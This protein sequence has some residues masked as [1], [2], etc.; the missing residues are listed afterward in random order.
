MFNAGEVRTILGGDFDAAGFDRFD[1]ATRG[2]ARNA[3][4]AEASIGRSA[5][6]ANASMTR[7]SAAA[8]RS[9]RS[10]ARY[11]AA[12][13]LAGA[14]IAGGAAL[15]AVGVKRSLNA[16][17]DFQQTLSVF[18]A[19]AGAT[20]RQMERV[21]RTAMALG[22]DLTLPGVSAADAA[23]AMTELA[24]GGLSVADSMAAA[25][26]VLQL[27]TAAQ[28]G[29]ADA[30]TIT[31]D[32]LNAFGL[33]GN[34]A[35]DVADMLANAANKSTATMPEMAEGLK[36]VSAVAATN[37]LSISTVVTALA[38]LAN[39]GIKGSDAGTSLKTM[40]TS[41][42]APTKE[43]K[44]TLSDMGVAVFDAQGAMRPFPEIIG[45]LK[46]ATRGMSEEQRAAAFNT[47]F[48]ADAVRAANVLVGEGERKH[49]ALARGIRESGAAAKLAAA[50]T[51]G[52]NGAVG[53]FQSQIETLSTQVGEALAP[54][55]TE[56]V[57]ALTDM[58]AGAPGAWAS[59]QA[60]AVPAIEWYRA[61][62][63]PTIAAIRGYWVQYHDEIMAVATFVWSTIVGIVQAQLAIIQGI[64]TA[65]L[66]VIRGDWD[67]A[68]EGLKMAVGGFRDYIG[69]ILSAAA[70]IASEAVSGIVAAAGAAAEGL[71]GAIADVAPDVYSAAVDLGGQA[72][73][74][75]GEGLADL[76]STAGDVA[77]DVPGAVSDAAGA[78]YSAAVGLGGEIVDGVVAGAARLA[79][80]IKSMAVAAVNGV[81]GMVN[82]ARIPTLAASVHVPG[83]SIPLPL[84]KSI[85][86]GGRDLGFDVGP[87]DL[88]DIPLLADGA[89]VKGPQLA[90]VGE[91][92]PEVVIP[93]GAKRT[94][95]G[96]RLLTYAAMALGLPFMADGG[97]VARGGRAPK[98][99]GPAR[100]GRWWVD[101]KDKSGNPQDS[102][103]SK[104]RDR[105]YDRIDRSIALA[106]LTKRTSDDIAAYGRLE[107]QLASDLSYARKHHAPPRVVTE[108]ARS[109]KSA[110]DRLAELKAK[111][112]PVPTGDP[113][114]VDP[115]GVDT[116]ADDAL[117]VQQLERRLAAE[118]AG[119]VGAESVLA[120]ITGSGDLGLAGVRSSSRG[121]TTVVVNT[122]HPGDPRTLA[123]V[124]GA[125]TLGARAA[126]SPRSP[127][128][129]R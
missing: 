8:G 28:I 12:A 129:G 38:Q 16:F 104:R 126:R 68:W 66:A 30:A 17:G 33:A 18:D 69:T 101:V 79:G 94:E 20:N 100:F 71:P 86:V 78:T 39:A 50:Q 115:P 128:V 113:P 89:V 119:R 19:T 24:K 87:F 114:G 121:G 72:I 75:I 49:R 77:D 53:A 62:V 67:G 10:V 13:R 54:A 14:G 99:K 95:R 123:A 21:K 107:R 2:A 7:S 108:I 27:A 106:D 29:N 82:A 58:A 105:V 1:R 73:D 3:A 11:A 42:A 55:A 47:I 90:V 59:I 45:D 15:V 91:D 22:N 122:L 9:G 96:R 25:K 5:A 125:A 57:N 43:A 124:A 116:S 97:V 63:T 98:P 74:G 81:L 120:S 60:A 31:A 44:D 70:T 110:R 109:L 32:A 111:P 84:G 23:T 118:A 127:R 76:A 61:N 46:R 36:Q 6:T 88:P 93:V 117:R 64:V 80:E 41:L 35:G 34:R 40:L 83:F 112:K 37:G 65:V 102:A 4:A 52:W 26:G 103:A 48:G 51:T 85:N 56:V 92:G